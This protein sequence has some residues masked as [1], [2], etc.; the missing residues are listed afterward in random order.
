MV[1]HL[2]VLR[3]PV[4]VGG[5]DQT[6]EVVAFT[7]L[8]QKCERLA[9]TR[10]ILTCALKHSICTKGMQC[11]LRTKSAPTFLGGADLIIQVGSD[12]LF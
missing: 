7:T 12:S 10:M 9:S 3:P 4:R 6:V 11:Y 2:T 1:T 5:Q 8:P